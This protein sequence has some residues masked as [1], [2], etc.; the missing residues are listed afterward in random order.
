M[1]S[2]RLARGRLH[3]SIMCHCAY[4]DFKT[5]LK[6][7]GG[8]M[9]LQWIDLEWRQRP[10]SRVVDTPCGKNSFFAWNCSVIVALFI[11]SY[12]YSISSFSITNIVNNS[13]KATHWAIEM[14]YLIYIAG[15]LQAAKIERVQNLT[16]IL[17]ASNLQ[18]VGHTRQGIYH[19]N[20]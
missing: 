10:R 3:S 18:P 6:F 4:G 13:H 17:L 16:I 19:K 15:K 5:G 20:T 7:V 8:S 1:F 11:P 12:A 14:K 9:T 2:A